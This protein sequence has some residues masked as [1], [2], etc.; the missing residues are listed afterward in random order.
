MIAVINVLTPPNPIKHPAQVVIP[1]A[2]GFPDTQGWV[3]TSGR[4]SWGS[5]LPYS[6]LM[7]VNPWGQHNPGKKIP[8]N[9]R[10]FSGL[11]FAFPF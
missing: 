8:A 6:E 7:T 11:T 3:G 10:F 9:T 5:A 1:F 4:S 2:C